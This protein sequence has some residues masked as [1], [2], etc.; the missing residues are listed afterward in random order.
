[1]IFTPRCEGIAFSSAYLL[2]VRFAIGLDTAAPGSGCD[3]SGEHTVLFRVDIPEPTSPGI[4]TEVTSATLKLFARRRRR[5]SHRRANS[6]TDDIVVVRVY[7]DQWRR[8]TNNNE[9]E[10][11]TV[12][13]H[14]G[15]GGGG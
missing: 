7:D 4:Q 5:V 10:V 13:R 2:T 1:M 12:R 14:R 9:T 3:A 11:M 8:L 6:P 15:G